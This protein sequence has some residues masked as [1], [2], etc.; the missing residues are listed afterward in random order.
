MPLRG[1]CKTAGSIFLKSTYLNAL[2]VCSP[3]RKSFRTAAVSQGKEQSA[4]NL[5]Q[6]CKDFA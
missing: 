6:L 3:K 1:K 2:T 4:Y 5:I